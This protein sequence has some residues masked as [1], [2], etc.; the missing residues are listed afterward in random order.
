MERES[1][2]RWR[3]KNPDYSRNYRNRHPEKIKQ[4]K[5]NYKRKHPLKSTWLAMKNRCYNK[6]R[7]RY[8]DC[9]GRGI[10]ICDE[11]LN[12]EKFEEWCLDNGWQQGLTIDRIDNNSGY[13]PNNCQ[14]ITR[15]ENSKKKRFC[16]KKG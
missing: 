15:S 2:R 4:Y 14:I 1:Q 6:N 16:A 8:K 10:T 13:C 12:Y 11:W 7:P 3:L 9:G 5:Q